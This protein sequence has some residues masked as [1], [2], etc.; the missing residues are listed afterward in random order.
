[1]KVTPARIE[2]VKRRAAEVPCADCAERERDKPAFTAQVWRKL[3]QIWQ[4]IEDNESADELLRQA[5]HLD[6]QAA[7]LRSIAE[8]R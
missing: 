4:E 1:V 2:A 8:S 3:E 6:A 5:D 7:R